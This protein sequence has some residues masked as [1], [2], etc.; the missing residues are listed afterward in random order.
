[1]RITSVPTV[2]THRDAT[3]P[4]TESR[5]PNQHFPIDVSAHTSV[6]Q[7]EEKWTYDIFKINRLYLVFERNCQ[8]ILHRPLTSRRK[9]TKYEIEKGRIGRV[10][11][12]RDK[13]IAQRE[14]SVEWQKC[15]WLFLKLV[16]V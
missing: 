13:T 8:L 11:I 9:K 4:K 12:I 10:K 15:R 3:K 14:S 7:N 16:R 5:R 1:M 2:C 6:L